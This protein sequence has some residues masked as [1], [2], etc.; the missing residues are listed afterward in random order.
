MP[1]VSSIYYNVLA[2]STWTRQKSPARYVKTLHNSHLGNSATR[3]QKHRSYHVVWCIFRQSE[4]F[5]R[6]SWVWQ[7]NWQTDRQNGL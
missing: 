7:T 5:R 6:G 3:N 2:Y 1:I 4:L